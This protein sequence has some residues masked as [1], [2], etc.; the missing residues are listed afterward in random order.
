M[1]EAR[2]ATEIVETTGNFVIVEDNFD[3]FVESQLGPVLPVC[4]HNLTDLV[5]AFVLIRKERN[6]APN[7]FKIGQYCIKCG[8]FEPKQ[9]PSY[10]K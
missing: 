4:P 9:N 6:H 3:N 5:D 10:P 2:E 7:Y 8:H 1:A